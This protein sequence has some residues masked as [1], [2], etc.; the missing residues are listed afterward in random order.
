[1]H[2]LNNTAGTL[3]LVGS[4]EMTPGMAR[5]HRFV[6]GRIEGEVRPAFLDTPAGFELNHQGIAE[7][8]VDYF[9]EQFG[10]ALEIASFP[11]AAA[12]TPLSTEQAMRTL[13]QAN[14]IFAGPGSPTYAV[15][16]LRNTPVFET[17][18]AKLGDGAHVVFASAAVL[19]LSRFT[20]PVYEI[21]KVGEDPR[22]ADG[23][24]LLGR[25]GFDLALVPHWNN[26]SGGN[27][28]TAR[29]FIGQPRF[30]R[31]RAALPPETVVLGVDEYTACTL[32][33]SEQMCEVFGAGSATVVR[34]DGER[35]FASGE[36]FPFEWLHQPG[37]AHE[38]GAFEHEATYTA[39]RA[40]LDEA[41]DPAH[42]LGLLHGLMEQTRRDRAAGAS[43]SGLTELMIR[44]MTASLAVWLERR[45]GQAP[46]ADPRA[47]VAPFVDALIGARQ[48]LRAAKQWA[49]ADQLRDALVRL[50]V[51]LEDAP[52]GASQGTQWRWAAPPA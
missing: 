21:Y 2:H 47:V 51:T 43:A 4:G 5:A 10:L 33:F 9:R 39:F 16:N 29:C 49:A 44:E 11:N 6:M 52:Q 31:L 22:W 1:M 50:G 35:S 19:S 12:A 42:A 20:I 14:Y 18:A 27:H 13:R 46:Q 17:I 37:R 32:C 30:D 26:T 24:D 36:R 23:L 48:G 40:A 3:T 8:A 34:A 38:H 25:F 41:A 15:R 28:D 7:K 45:G